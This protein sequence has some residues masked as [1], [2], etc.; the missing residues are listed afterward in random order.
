MTDV[1][2]PSMEESSPPSPLPPRAPQPS[3]A[4][5][6]TNWLV[7]RATGALE[8]R[9]SRRGFLIGSAMAG[10]AVA[11]VGC[12]VATSPG[13]PYTHI[14][15][16]A[17]GACTDGYTEF[18][19]SV[20]NGLNLCPPDSFAGGW[21]RADYSSFCSGT[22]YYIDC[23]QYCAGPATGYQNFCAGT[24]ECRCADGC[25]TRRVYC[26][27]FRYGQCHQELTASGPIACRIVT[28]TPP[29][30]V[31]D[32]ACST[33]AAVDNSTAEHAGNCPVTYPLDAAVLPA[34]GDATVGA[35]G[36]VE[37][38]VRAADN[39]AWYRSSAGSTWGSWVSLGGSLI[40]RARAVHHQGDVFMFA[41]ATNGALWSRRRTGSAWT[42]W[43]NLDGSLNSDPT[44]VS[45]SSGLYVFS[46]ATN[47]AIWYRRFDGTWGPWTSL[48]GTLSSNPVVVNGPDGMFLVARADDFMY[49]YRRFDGGSWSP[50]QQ[51]GGS[52]LASD[53]ALAAGPDG[54]FLFGRGF[55]SQIYVRR[56]QAGAWD[57]NWQALGGTITSDPAAAVDPSGTYVFGRAADNA[58]WSRR[59]A[60]GV[61]DPWTFLDGTL[62]ADPIAVTAPSGMYVFAVATGNGLWSRRRTVSG[63]E[64]WVPL[65]G[66]MAPIKGGI[67]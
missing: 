30:T 47:R 7:S 38:Y 57:A 50:W 27:Y 64:P 28:C 17:G 51:V 65:G 5:A 42:A 37:V 40:S 54:T 45:H 49:W 48:G 15:D 29:Y 6:F 19:C 46:R 23:M 60:N 34:T 4:I 18:C 24:V 33:A 52:W 9:S 11:V 14:T 53:P 2:E 21:W 32:W 13:P 66:T 39:G 1:V 63:W 20:N 41:R 3:K 44:A 61:W 59:F 56:Y 10:S 12:T 26:N 8:K 62:V 43:A 58:L 22:R 67:G 35:D 36:T 55:D 16:C 25:N 31:A